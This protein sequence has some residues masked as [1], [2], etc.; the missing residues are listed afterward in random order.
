[1]RYMNFKIVFP[2]GVVAVDVDQEKRSQVFMF[3]CAASSFAALLA[4]FSVSPS[5]GN[6][7]RAAFCFAVS[8]PLSLCN[9][10]I[11]QNTLRFPATTSFI[12]RLFWCIGLAAYFALLAGLAFIL[13]HFSDVHGMVFVAFSLLCFIIWS[14]HW[15]KLGRIEKRSQKEV[16]PPSTNE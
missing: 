8:L 3:G 10:M 5:D 6:I 16:L 7:S 12:A 4:T 14:L 1:M 2:E 13:C 15:A 9:A 11:S